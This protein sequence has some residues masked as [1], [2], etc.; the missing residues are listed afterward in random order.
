VN[1]YLLAR[2]LNRAIEA[3]RADDLDTAARTLVVVT[4]DRMDTYIGILG[5]AKTIADTLDLPVPVGA[6]VTAATVEVRPAP[7]G[8]DDNPDVVDADD[9]FTALVAAR[10]N[11]DMA[12]AAALLDQLDD[13]DLAT[14]LAHG[15]AVVATWDDRPTPNHQGDHPE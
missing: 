13:P 5:Y 3:I 14:L 4:R 12:G 2:H 15:A 6:D 9:R 10:I 7:W 11:D 8:V 1:A